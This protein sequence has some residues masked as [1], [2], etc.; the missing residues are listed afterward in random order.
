MISTQFE[1]RQP[2]Q[3]S[4]PA[5]DRQPGGYTEKA[6]AACCAGS[7][8]PQQGIVPGSRADFL[9]A[10]EVLSD[11]LGVRSTSPPGVAA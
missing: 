9:Q 3:T 4:P 11:D 6:I 10:L 5:R 7:V 1:L 8:V 2:R